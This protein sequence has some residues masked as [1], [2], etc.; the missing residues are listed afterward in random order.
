MPDEAPTQKS[1]PQPRRY[2]R[3]AVV[4]GSIAAASA[5]IVYAAL[6]GELFGGSNGEGGG[7]GLAAVR[8]DTDAISSESVKVSHLLRRAGF[9]AS[10]E[11]HDR[12]QT[13]GLQKTL[14]ELINF[15][16]VD[17]AEALR[18]AN[19]IDV[20]DPANRAAPIGWW[21]L[22]M[23]NTKRPLQEKLTLFWHSLLTSQITVVKDP[24]AMVAQ[25]EFL[26]GHA[27]DTFPNVLS[28]ISN[29]RAMM[30]YLDVDGSSRRAP[31][32]NYARELMELFALGVG[33]YT[34]TDVREAARA[35]TGWRV[36]KTRVDQVAFTLAAPVFSPQL[37]DNGT[38][39]FLGKTGNFRGEDIVDIIVD[40]PASAS[41]IVRRLFAY[42]VFPEPTDDD[43][44]PF[45]DV[46]QTSNRSTGAVV[47]AMLRSDVFY[48][49]R[50]YR[51]VVKSPLEYAVGAIRAL[52]L[53]ST[54]LQL[55]QQAGLGRGGGYL[56]DMGQVPFEP[57]NV[58][59]W[60]GGTH[61]LNSATIFSRLNLINTLTGGEPLPVPDIGKLSP[62]QLARL[63]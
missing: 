26:R 11:E 34:E 46:Y 59:G 17:D 43:I 28:G 8:G 27:T 18:I 12:Y 57:P 31:N 62:Q 19:Q 10:K 22:R 49:P 42:F 37:F 29:D 35:F 38:K 40:Q 15:T 6:G 25:N 45:V 1:S 41:Y 14:D 44:A 36:P 33:N 30:V 24:T 56:T 63:K 20:T 23:A 39:T 54:S 16:A 21:I 32:E 50:A 48:S 55:L 2:T 4:G 52:G 60:P 9:G 47:E 13:L 53:Q 3:R 61:W 58:A 7:A 5:A 51:A